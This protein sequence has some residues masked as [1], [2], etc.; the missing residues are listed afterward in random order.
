M[1][2]PSPRRGRPPG[3]TQTLP[4]FLHQVNSRVPIRAI[5]SAPTARELRCYVEWARELITMANDE[6]LVRVVD[7]ALSD[8]FKRDRLWRPIRQ[9]I[10]ADHDSREWRE[11]FSAMLNR[12]E[13][14]GPR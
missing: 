9:T 3:P 2:S 8:Y 4:L 6:V 14:V 12:K 13:D 7:Q 1:E 10:L 11:K 5:V